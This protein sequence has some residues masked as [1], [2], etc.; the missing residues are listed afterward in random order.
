MWSLCGSGGLHP[1]SSPTSWEEA[2]AWTQISLFLGLYRDWH[3]VCSVLLVSP[4][5]ELFAFIWQWSPKQ[6]TSPLETCSDQWRQHNRAA[7]HGL[8]VRRAAAGGRTSVFSL[9][10]QL[11]LVT[12]KGSAEGIEARLWSRGKLFMAAATLLQPPAVPHWHTGH[13]R[14]DRRPGVFSYL[15]FELAQTLF[16]GAY[17]VFV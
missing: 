4:V 2:D 1:N 17:H 12:A 8:R 10:L 13:W 14:S 11:H 16:R 15:C 5:A 6:W 7:Q 3:P 9:H